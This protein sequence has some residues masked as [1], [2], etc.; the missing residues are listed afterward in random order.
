MSV[1]VKNEDLH[2]VHFFGESTVHD[3]ITRNWA[4][5]FTTGTQRFIPSYVE[6]LSR[7]NQHCK[8]LL[9]VKVKFT[10]EEAT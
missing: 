5:R 4:T 8:V 1:A 7:V 2:H 3:I 10:V 6:K 9:K